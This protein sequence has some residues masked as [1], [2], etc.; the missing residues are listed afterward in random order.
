M[1]AMAKEAKM[2]VALLL[3]RIDQFEK[4]ENPEEIFHSLGQFVKNLLR[5]KDVLVPSA[6]GRYI[7]L[8]YNTTAESGKKIA[9]RLKEKINSHPFSSM[10]KLTIS[11]AVSSMDANAK[12]F[13]AMINSAQKSLRMQT[14]SDLII[15]LDEENL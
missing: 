9:E 15:S 11:I 12:E 8:L 5:E 3:L 13:Q 2:P 4:W 10:R 14:D 6:E 1:L 7:L